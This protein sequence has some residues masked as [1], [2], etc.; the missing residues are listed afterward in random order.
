MP[1]NDF[2]FLGNPDEVKNEIAKIQLMLQQQA[3]SYTEN[4]NHNQ[5]EDLFIF[6]PPESRSDSRAQH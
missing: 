2:G 5:Q 4:E 6:D 3:E 1:N